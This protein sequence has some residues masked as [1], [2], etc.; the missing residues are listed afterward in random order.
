MF[1][2][3]F[4]S[5]ITIFFEFSPKKIKIYIKSPKK[6]LK[7]PFKKCKKKQDETDILKTEAA[8]SAKLEAQMEKYRCVFLA[9]LTYLGVKKCLFSL[10]FDV[11]GV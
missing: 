5:K 2:I 6:I 1:H 8:K 10:F 7:N 3:F 4:F 11:F 9:F